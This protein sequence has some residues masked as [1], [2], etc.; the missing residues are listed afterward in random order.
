MAVRPASSGGLQRSEFHRQAAGA[1]EG[2]LPVS[3]VLQGEGAIWMQLP[4]L[5]DGS[6]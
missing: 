2:T 3:P 4:L 6:S 1:C 5:V